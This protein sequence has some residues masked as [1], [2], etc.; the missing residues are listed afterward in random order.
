MKRS[1]TLTITAALLVAASGVALAEATPKTGTPTSAECN[2]IYTAKAA[3]DKDI[4]TKQLAHDLQLP[5]ETVRHCLRL[6]RSQ[7]PRT[8]PR[9]GE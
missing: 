5:V 1:S 4:S 2:R 7:G 6:K 8:T 9:A 3:A